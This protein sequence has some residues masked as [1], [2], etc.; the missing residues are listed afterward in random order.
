M[1]TRTS[2]AAPATALLTRLAELRHQAALLVEHRSAGDPTAGDPLRGLY[3]SDE[4]VR[5]LL[6]PAEPLPLACPDPDGPPG[7]R[8][9]ELS[10]R[11]GLTELDSALL[12]IALAP[13]LDRG[14]E[15]LYGYLNDD[16]S[17]RRA[18]VALALDLCG[19][20]VHLAGHGPGCAPRPR[21][22]RSVCSPWRSPN[23]P[24][25]AARCGCRTG[26]WRIS[27]ATT[28]LTRHSTG[29]ST[30]CRTPSPETT[31][32]SPASPGCWPPAS[33]PGRPSPRT[34]GRAARATGSPASPRPC[35][36]RASRP[37]GSRAPRTGFP[38]CCA[39]P[40]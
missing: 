39:R 11:L 35:G 16:V 25:S 36:A 21:C 9:A 17:R 8:L 10:A 6:R 14:F 7:D 20:P 4:A 2:E 5:H 33:P 38:I 27:S 15:P 30:R 12:L 26:S 23:G 29:T 37:C 32:S 40:G 24:S 19:V 22:P 1:T 13:D 3:L 28:P 31:R 34:S 18:T